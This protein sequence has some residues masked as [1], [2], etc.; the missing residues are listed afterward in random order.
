M[1]LDKELAEV[2]L[3]PSQNWG[4]ALSISKKQFDEWTISQLAAQGYGH[5]KVSYMPVLVNI[6]PDG[7]GNKELAQRARVTKQAMSKVLKELLDYGYISSKPSKEDKRN[8]IISLTDKGKKLVIASRQCM[9]Q[10]MDEYRSVFGKKEFDDLLL[11]LH[12][13]I[14]YNDQKL[15]SLK[16]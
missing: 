16:R 1:N 12:R 10:L 13:M 15:Q 3:L 11:M 14:E 5:F 2:S 8:A 6:G 7:M 4:K 9:R